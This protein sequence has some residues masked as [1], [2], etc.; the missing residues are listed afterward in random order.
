LQQVHT[1]CAQ[2]SGAQL[3]SFTFPSVQ[4]TAPVASQYAD[5]G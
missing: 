2:L 1:F 4:A 3:E 5:S